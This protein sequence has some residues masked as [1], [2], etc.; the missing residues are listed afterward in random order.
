MADNTKC[1]TASLLLWCKR[2]ASQITTNLCGRFLVNVKRL[3]PARSFI[4]IQ[5][6]VGKRA[7]DRE[8]RSVT[9]GGRYPITALLICAG[10]AGIVLGSTSSIIFLLPAALMAFLIGAV[11]IVRPECW[12]NR[13]HRHAVLRRLFGRRGNDQ[14]ATALVHAAITRRVTGRALFGVSEA[15]HKRGGPA[16]ICAGGAAGALALCTCTVGS[17]KLRNPYV[18]LSEIA[19]CVVDRCHAANDPMESTGGRLC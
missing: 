14:H 18:R 15:E 12:P 6:T 13:S 9:S 17:P 19:R 1:Q 10:V 2:E 5:F 4:S 16:S 8:G 7:Q 11:L 3:F